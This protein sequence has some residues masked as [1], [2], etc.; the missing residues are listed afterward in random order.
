MIPL[1]VWATD[2]SSVWGW[3][4]YACT[5]TE[6]FGKGFSAPC[7]RATDTCVNTDISPPV[8]TDIHTHTHTHTHNVNYVQKA[9][10]VMQPAGD[11]RTQVGAAVFEI[12]VRSPGSLRL[13]MAVAAAVAVL[14][15]L[16]ALPGRAR[17]SECKR[18]F[19]VE[20]IGMV[21]PAGARSNWQLGFLD[22]RLADEMARM[23][24][25]AAANL[26]A[27]CNCSLEVSALVRPGEGGC[28]AAPAPAYTRTVKAVATGNLVESARA[29]PLASASPLFAS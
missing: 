24:A 9:E 3:S 23:P 26:F 7:W 22:I 10:M 6:S 18:L 29:S 12:L 8:E 15:A 5:G 14:V 16:A 13:V 17:G 2:V 1:D 25:A 11:S 19:A 27:A 21:A 20:E 28:L 4:V